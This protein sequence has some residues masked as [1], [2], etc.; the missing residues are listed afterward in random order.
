MRVLDSKTLAVLR[1]RNARF[2]KMTIEQRRVAIAKDVLAQLSEKKIVATQGTYVR[3]RSMRRDP[4]VHPGQSLQEVMEATKG[5]TCNV[6]AKGAV[7]VSAVRLGNRVAGRAGGDLSYSLRENLYLVLG[8]TVGIGFSNFLE[9][10]FEWCYDHSNIKGWDLVSPKNRMVFLM[11]TTIRLK[12]VFRG[13]KAEQHFE[14]TLR[15]IMQRAT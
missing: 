2:E 14:E 11:E 4:I 8:R 15:K 10:L 6:C 12:G 13:S 5:F 3:S 1:R 9:Q 7:L